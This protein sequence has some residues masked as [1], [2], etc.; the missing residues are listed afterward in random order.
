MLDTLK[1]EDEGLEQLA[2][3]FFNCPDDATFRSELLDASLLDYSLESLSTVDEYLER[4]RD[5]P[6]NGNDRIK[7]I[8]RAGAYIG[9]VIRRALPTRDTHWV[10][11]SEAVKIDASFS[12]MG[13]QIGNYYSLYHGGKSFCFPL[14]KVEKRIVDGSEN[15]VLSFARVIIDLR[16]TKKL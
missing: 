1:F 9:E 15:N 5:C 3:M 11:Y 8:V 6:P 14:A 2:E 12:R 16:K 4:L 7:C 10:A 13:E